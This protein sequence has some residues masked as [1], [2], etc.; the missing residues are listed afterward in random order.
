MLAGV[1]V[2]LVAVDVALAVVGL[3]SQS[4][5]PRREG[6]KIAHIFDNYLITFSYQVDCR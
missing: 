4:L 3:P 2:V 1:D 6:V 5:C